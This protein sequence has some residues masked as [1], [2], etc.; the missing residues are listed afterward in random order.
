MTALLSVTNHWVL[1]LACW[2]NSQVS[3]PRFTTYQLCNLEKHNF[4]RAWLM[5]VKCDDTFEM[6]ETLQ[7]FLKI[8]K[9]LQKLGVVANTIILALRRWRQDLKF[10]VSLGCIER[11]CFK[12]KNT[13]NMP[14]MASDTC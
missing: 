2:E 8:N 11:P 9:M 1:G 5:S 4:P 6:Y 12:K 3:D 13:Y 10:K 14:N 7:G